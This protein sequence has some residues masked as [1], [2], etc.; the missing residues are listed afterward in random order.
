MRAAARFAVYAAITS[1][2]HLS[3]VHQIQN[4]VES[5][6]HRETFPIRSLCRRKWRMLHARFDPSARKELC[7]GRFEFNRHFGFTRIFYGLGQG[8]GNGT[9]RKPGRGERCYQWG[10]LSCHESHASASIQ[11]RQS[12]FGA[13]SRGPPHTRNRQQALPHRP[14][15]QDIFSSNR[16]T[17]P[18]PCP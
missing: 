18:L 6:F 9:L 5:L 10:S 13:Q 15:N 17:F 4:G 1:R 7:C 2:H 11:V 14:I 12:C 3:Q 8:S 16:A